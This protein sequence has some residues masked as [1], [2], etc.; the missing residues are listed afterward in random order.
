M[1]I[2]ER[3]PTRVL[4][5][6]DEKI[7]HSP[8]VFSSINKQWVSYVGKFY[9]KWRNLRDDIRTDTV[10]AIK[11]GDIHS[12]FI[13]EYKKNH[14]TTENIFLRLQETINNRLYCLDSIQEIQFP[15]ELQQ[16]IG[17]YIVENTINFINDQCFAILNK[18]RIDKLF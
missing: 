7:T 6:N 5:K 16:I 13:E 1:S 12:I 17:D 15:V 4:R 9:K 3:K 11:N 10:L 2:I 8:Y 14:L 18:L